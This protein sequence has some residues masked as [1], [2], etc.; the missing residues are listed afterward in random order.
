MN[1]PFLDLKPV[2]AELQAELDAAWRRAVSSG[3]YILGAEV[4]AFEAEF[5]AY[6]GARH[7]VGVG[8]GLDAIHLILRALGIGPG[9]EVLVPSNTFIATWLG[10]T[11]AGATPV[12]VEPDEETFN[13]DPARLEA[14][15]TGRT[16]A[17][18]P[19]HLYGQ[20]ADMD[21]IN[22]VAA[23]YGLK[24]VEDAAQAQGARYK[25]RRAGALADAAAF[26]FYPGKN[27][28]ALGDAGAVVTDDAALAERVRVLSN[29]G[30]R[31]KYAHEVRG[32]NS[33]LDELQAAL[34]RAKLPRLDEWNERR[35]RVAQIYTQALEGVPDLRLPRAPAWAEPVWHLYVVRH[36]ERARLREHLAARGVGTLIHYPLPPHLQ[37][38]YAD[39]GC[40]PG[41]FPVAER[42]AREVL[43]LPMGPH[44]AAAE[45]EYVVAQASAFARQ[46]EMT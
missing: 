19:V 5:A 46:P 39:M 32:V 27:L 7:C 4:A 9:D 41:A 43:S 23:R 12:P 24:V 20:C 10:V 30:S 29:Y 45:A 1:V 38:A 21:A 3:W 31:V 35:R 36:P 6:C 28:G 15:I 22:A 34:L 37:P 18:V 25:G 26:S 11:Y 17:I 42:M 8:N 13:L 2:Y 14:A 16:R 44:L 40:A 33:R